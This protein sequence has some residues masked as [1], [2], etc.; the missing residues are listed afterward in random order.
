MLLFH[1]CI[2]FLWLHVSSA[3][4][5]ILNMAFPFKILTSRINLIPHFFLDNSKFWMNHSQKNINMS[6]PQPKCEIKP[7]FNRFGWKPALGPSSEY[8]Q[9][10]CWICPNKS[11]S[12]AALPST[13]GSSVFASFFCIICIWS[14]SNSDKQNFWELDGIS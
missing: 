7:G 3:I 10:Q 6:K 12:L 8:T 14:I 11:D 9:N 1:Q 5:I 2:I 4:Q 13:F